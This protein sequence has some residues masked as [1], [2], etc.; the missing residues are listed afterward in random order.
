M[1]ATIWPASTGCYRSGMKGLL[2][3][4]GPFRPP[5]APGMLPSAPGQGGA[6][7]KNG[8]PNVL[9][10]DKGTSRLAQGPIAHTCLIE[11][12]KFE[13]EAPEATA[14]K[15]TEIIEASN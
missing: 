8:I 7:C 1:N 9:T 12:E 10:P 13:G 3:L 14:F 11:L 2:R 4:T 6:P 15:P 5:L